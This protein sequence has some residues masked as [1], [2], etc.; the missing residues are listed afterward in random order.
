MGEKC[1]PLLEFQDHIMPHFKGLMGDCLEPKT[2]EHDTFSSYANYVSL[3][4][5][6]LLKNR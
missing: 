3:K 6:D 5:G 2:I 4:M 1:V